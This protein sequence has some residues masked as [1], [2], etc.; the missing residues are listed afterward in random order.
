MSDLK[1]AIN[2]QF[3][4][5]IK[6]QYILVDNHIK[7]LF[8]IQKLNVQ[9]KFCKIINMR[10]LNLRSFS[11][12]L[13]RNVLHTASHNADT[14]FIFKIFILNCTNLYYKFLKAFK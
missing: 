11:L 2:I 3:L 4:N 6:K 14:N 10:I 13:K 5:P 1:L 12:L 7:P 8:L 9:S